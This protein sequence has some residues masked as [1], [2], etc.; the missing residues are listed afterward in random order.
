MTSVKAAKSPTREM[1]YVLLR[2]TKILGQNLDH[3]S[4]G[5]DPKH[6]CFDWMRCSGNG[7]D[8]PWP[9]SKLALWVWEDLHFDRH[10]RSCTSLLRNHFDMY[11][12]VADKSGPIGAI[13]CLQ[14]GKSRRL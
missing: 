3:I 1:T 2:Q 4:T 7:C 9:G 12:V 14:L 11:T 13:Y 5:Y 6:I 8:A 10:P